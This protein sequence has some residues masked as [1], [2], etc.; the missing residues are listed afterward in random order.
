MY[1][2]IKS[3]GKQYR[4][5]K[6]DVISVDLLGQNNGSQVHFGDVL[7]VF[8]GKNSI[9]GASHLAHFS[10]KG[11]VLGEVKG[12]KLIAMKYKRRKQER[13]TFGHRERYSSVRITEIVSSSKKGT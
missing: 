3:G 8:D 5:A 1:A 9:V 12:E 10:V 2:I 11:E 6:D 7:F 13:K 4:V